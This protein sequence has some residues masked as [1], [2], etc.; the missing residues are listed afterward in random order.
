MT[1]QSPLPFRIQQRVR[2]SDCDPL[3]IIWYGAYLK[4]FEAAE[5]EMMRATNLPYEELRVKRGVQLPRKAFQVEFQSP[6][7]MDELLDVEVGVA[8]IGQ[9]S[10]TFRFAAYRATDRT[11]RATAT[12]TVV[13]VEKAT[14]RKQPIPEFL[15]EALTPF[16]VGS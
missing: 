5:H 10:L 9:T 13:N 8:K 11:L 15:R 12:L 4:Y 1:E 3:G 2:W 16:L 7:Q 6:A 14:L